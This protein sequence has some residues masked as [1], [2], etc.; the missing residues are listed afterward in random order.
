MA[1]EPVAPVLAYDLEGNPRAVALMDEFFR[2]PAGASLHN[3]EGQ[4]AWDHF[5]GAGRR[6]LGGDQLYFYSAEQFRACLEY[7]DKDLADRCDELRSDPKGNVVQIGTDSQ[8]LEWGTNFTH[9]TYKQP[10]FGVALTAF[11]KHL[12]GFSRCNRQTHFFYYP[13]GSYREW[14][15]NEGSPHPGWR[16]YFVKAKEPGKSFFSYVEADQVVHV[17]DHRY[18]IRVFR[19][20][21][22]L[23]FYHSVC[24]VDTDRWSFGVGPLDWPFDTVTE[25]KRFLD[26]RLKT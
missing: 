18:G 21:G 5:L 3:K 26:Q 8:G 11:A 13:K 9:F 24:A 23:K 12:L 17:P 14:H 22:G 19:F 16:V 10:T 6:A 25:A 1:A 15:T 7:P 2:E 20:G 4:L